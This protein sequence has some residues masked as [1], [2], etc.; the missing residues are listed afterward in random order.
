MLYDIL[1][2]EDPVDNVKNRA[3]ELMRALDDRHQE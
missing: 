2:S 3:K 1:A